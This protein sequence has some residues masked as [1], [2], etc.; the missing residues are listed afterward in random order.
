MGGALLELVAKGSQDIF[1]TGNPNTTYFRSVYKRHTNFSSESIIQTIDGAVNFGKKIE[2]VIARSGDLLTS[3]IVEI[4]LPK[5]EGK[6]G[7]DIY[8]VDAIGHHL[9]KSVE[10]EIGGLLIDRHYGEWLEIW[11]ELTM[12]E[13]K[14]SAYNSMIGKGVSINSER[15]LFVPL[16]FWFCRNYG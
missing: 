7:K 15:T 16:Q 12:T 8:W 2:C 11:T 10:I 3:V 4:D 13:A 14:K 6:R 9:I 5:L 1:L